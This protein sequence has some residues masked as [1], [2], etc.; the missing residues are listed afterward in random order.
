[1][2]N[3]VL[4]VL[5]VLAAIAIGVIFYQLNELSHAAECYTVPL[6]KLH[7]LDCEKYL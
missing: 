1:M 3:K 5:A 2:L 7:S 4:I 6:E